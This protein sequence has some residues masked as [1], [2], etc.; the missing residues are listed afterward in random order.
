MDIAGLAVYGSS[1]MVSDLTFTAN[2]R[3][4]PWRMAAPLP[5]APAK[6]HLGCWYDMKNNRETH[7]RGEAGM[8]RRQCSA[9]PPQESYRAMAT[10]G[11]EA[12]TGTSPRIRFLTK[13]LKAKKARSAAVMSNA[14]VI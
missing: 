3:R 1:R 7:R 6:C 11:G 9:L 5:C 8:M 12:S 13:G 4:F 10:P 14:A 2:P